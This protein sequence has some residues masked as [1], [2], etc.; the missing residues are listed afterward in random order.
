MEIEQKLKFHNKKKKKTTGEIISDDC[1]FMRLMEWVHLNEYSIFLVDSTTT[2]HSAI[3]TTHI[4]TQ[5]KYSFIHKLL[6]Y[7]MF[8]S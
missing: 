2:R 4:S 1:H 3:A 7:S 8:Q 5:Q 6:F